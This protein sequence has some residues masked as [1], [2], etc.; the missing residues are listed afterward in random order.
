MGGVCSGGGCLL[1]GEGGL[2]RGAICLQGVSD[3]GGV[4]SGGG[5]SRGCLTRGGLLQGGLPQTHPPVNRMTDRCKNI[6][7]ATTS[8]RPVIIHRSLQMGVH[9]NQTRCEHEPFHLH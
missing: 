6:T 4:C 5:C 1:P 8:L 2:L 7:L 9:S 3:P